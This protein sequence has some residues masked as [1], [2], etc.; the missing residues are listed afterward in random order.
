MPTADFG[1]PLQTP[2][3][4]L[5]IGRARVPAPRVRRRPRSRPNASNAQD[6]SHQLT[7][8]C[9]ELGGLTR[10]TVNGD[11]RAVCANSFGRTTTNKQ[12]RVGRPGVSA[13]DSAL[14]V[15]HGAILVATGFLRFRFAGGPLRPRHRADLRQRLARTSADRPWPDWQCGGQGFESPQL[16]PDRPGRFPLWEAASVTSGAILVATS[17]A[18]GPRGPSP[19]GRLPHALGRA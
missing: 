1:G 4:R 3:C 14:L 9:M 11:I 16:H 17:F 6:A 7:A 2:S 5:V 18:R 15:L 12:D 19:S 8:K 10:G 13:G